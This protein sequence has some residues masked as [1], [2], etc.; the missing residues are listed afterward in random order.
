M[1][2]AR[3]IAAILLG[4]MVAVMA[5]CAL[6]ALA[7]RPNIDFALAHTLLGVAAGLTI[8]ALVATLVWSRR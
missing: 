4:L 6:I 2:P 5:L 8:S 7:T 1:H 3:L